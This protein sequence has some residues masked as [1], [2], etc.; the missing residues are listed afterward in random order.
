MHRVLVN[1]G[2]SQEAFRPSTPCI[3]IGPIRE[4]STLES[5]WD[6]HSASPQ[7]WSST[8][9]G[10]ILLS[11]P[12]VDTA[13]VIP[14]T[15]HDSFPPT[16]S[17]FRAGAVKSGEHDTSI[18]PQQWHRRLCHPGKAQFA[19]LVGSQLSSCYPVTSDTLHSLDFPC[20]A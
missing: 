16:L 14:A 8:R 9:R 13:L 20:N 19:S 3:R 6:G 18:G 7:P 2:S 1:F 12:L 11:D 10:T 4:W 15:T 5:S 17:A